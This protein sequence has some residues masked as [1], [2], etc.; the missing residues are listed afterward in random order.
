MG[1]RLYTYALS[2]RTLQRMAAQ[3]DQLDDIL[4]GIAKPPMDMPGASPL[5]DRLAGL[6]DRMRPTLEE[7]ATISIDKAW[8]ALHFLL[9]GTPWD[10]E[11]PLDFLLKGSVEIADGEEDERF[12]HACTASETQAIHDALQGIGA[13]QLQQRFEPEQLLKLAIYPYMGQQ[14]LPDGDDLRYCLHHFAKLKSFVDRAARSRLG[15]L[16]CRG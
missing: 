14:P 12:V 8:H 3:P 4:D 5:L 16:I 1:I 7:G 6:M 13:E 11:P 10:G 2:D 15:L 9:T